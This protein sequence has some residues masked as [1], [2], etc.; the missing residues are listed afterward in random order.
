M[1]DLTGETLSG[2]YFLREKAG[3]GGMAD[4][5]LAMDKFRSTKMA[6]K[7]LKRDL[8][9]NDTFLEQFSTEAEIYSQ[10]THPNIVRFYE[11][12]K[13]GDIVYIV[14]DWVDG[15]DLRK[16]IRNTKD[17]LPYGSIIRILQLICPALKYAHDNEIFHCDIKPANI[18]LQNDGKVLLTDFSVANLAWRS[19]GGGTPPYTAPEQ[20]NGDK[21]DART[22]IYA[23][24]ITLYEILAGGR[25]PYR[26][27]TASSKGTTLKERI[28][29]EHL[30]LSPP[31][32][33]NYNP[34]VPPAVEKVIFTSIN[35][36]PERRY[37]SVLELQDAFINACN[38]SGY[39]ETSSTRKTIET[40]I[41]KPDPPRSPSRK[42]ARSVNN[43]DSYWPTL[44]QGNDL[45]EIISGVLKRLSQPRAVQKVPR[46]YCRAG[47]Y[48]GMMIDL[49]QGEFIIGRAQDCHLKLYENSVSRRHATIIHSVRGLY[50]RD[51]TSSLGT[52][53][54]NVRIY[55][56]VLLHDRDVIQIGYEQVFEVIQHAKF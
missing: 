44:R 11:F 41:L 19:S 39:S 45:P 49:P 52:Y 24:G 40:T 29:W 1:N 42:P 32:L 2:Q 17:P 37:Q 12:K 22:D 9:N 26:G 16:V 15:S 48:A 4:V 55:A 43:Q 56:S 3:S 54:N 6:V 18:L 33:S 23:L 35:K 31:P 13:D 47:Q 50:I 51:D 30:H 36:K 46:L 25:T 28:E 8:T 21:I 14:M 10:L 20:F 27:E 34:D 53:V 5:Y 7:V 38:T